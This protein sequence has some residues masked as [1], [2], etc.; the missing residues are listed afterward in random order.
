[1][2][3]ATASL[4]R[5]G[6]AHADGETV[7]ADIDLAVRQATGLTR[8]LLAY[9]RRENIAPALVSVDELVTSSMPLLRQVVGSGL[10]LTLALATTEE[11]VVIDDTQLRQV[12]INLVGNAADATRGFG[13]QVRVSTGL[14]VLESDQARARGLIAEGPFVVLC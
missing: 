13:R 12:L 5:G 2:S 8:S 4:G 11:R 14:V 10:E 3:T 7:R 9:A 1:I 6:A